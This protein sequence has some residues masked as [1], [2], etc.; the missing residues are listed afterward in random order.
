MNRYYLVLLATLA[1]LISAKSGD[2]AG[3]YER[4]LIP[5][6]GAQALPGAFG[7]LWTSEFIVRNNSDSYIEILQ[8][9]SGLCGACPL[10]PVQP[11]TTLAYLAN[12]PNPGAGIFLYVPISGMPNIS[13]NARI[14]DVSRQA[15]TWGTEI[16]IVH[17]REAVS[18]TLYLVNVP[19][20][21]RFRQTL[22]IY[23]FDGRDGAQVMVRVYPNA[24]STLLSESVITLKQGSID[25][26]PS[27]GW[28]AMAQLAFAD[29]AGA[30]LV[31][32]TRLRLE[33]TP[34]TPA[35]RIWAFVS[36]TN[37]ETQ[38]VTTITPQ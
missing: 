24:S 31:N 25:D 30:P 7:S 26:S 22:R 27:P 19:A 16:P 8:R 32:G 9:L 5:V 20:D 23:D 28:P 15:L 11:R 33:I 10:P 6:Y 37:N 21:D 34:I 18:G 17:E 35:L 38:H 3:P 2:A 1:I 12:V 14:Q 13:F 29:I 4:I 36:V